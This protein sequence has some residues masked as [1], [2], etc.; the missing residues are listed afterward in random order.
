[1]S[2]SAT[3]IP[4]HKG[5]GQ[6]Q[7]KGFGYVMAV[8]MAVLLIVAA[9]GVYD[10]R[11]ASV[12]S[13]HANARTETYFAEQSGSFC[14]MEGVWHNWEDDETITLGCLE[15]R[16]NIRKGSYS[17]AMGPRATWSFSISGTYDLDSDSSMQVAGKDQYGQSVKFTSPFYVDDKEYPTQ[18]IVIDKMGGK[19]L[20]IWQR[21]SGDHD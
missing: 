21:N 4:S 11:N 7:G 5:K 14:V 10:Y 15:V 6:A 8:P 9:N 13:A 12:K 16:G 20:Y 19:N 17:S 1:M 3:R 2:E 18:M